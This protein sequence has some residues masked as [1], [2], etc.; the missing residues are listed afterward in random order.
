[1]FK[2]FKVLENTHSY[3]VEFNFEEFGRLPSGFNYDMNENQDIVGIFCDKTDDNKKI[4]ISLCEEYFEKEYFKKEEEYCNFMA[5]LRITQE[6]NYYFREYLKV[7]TTLKDTETIEDQMSNQYYIDAF[8][9]YE[10]DHF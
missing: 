1:M 5:N 8:K 7:Y 3:I 2:V 4:L 10:N 6:R 9:K